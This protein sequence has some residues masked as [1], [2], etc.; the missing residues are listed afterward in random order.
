MVQ[1]EL[2]LP[3]IQVS[4]EVALVIMVRYIN[5]QPCILIAERLLGPNAGQLTFP[6]GTLES[7]E[8][9]EGCA[10]R[11]LREETGL[12]VKFDY[13]IEAARYPFALFV[14]KGLARVTCFFTYWDESTG[15]IDPER[16]EPGKHKDW[17][18]VPIPHA[19]RL[20]C[21]GKLPLQVF[22]GWWVEEVYDTQMQL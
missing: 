21:A 13:L 15:E 7:G 16:S 17:M 20:A 6:G 14:S 3:E 19:V 8:D 18:W 5:S 4:T 22:Q 10:L 2:P 1:T 11:E 9:P 12:T